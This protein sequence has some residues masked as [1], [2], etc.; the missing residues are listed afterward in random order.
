MTVAAV[1][2][3]IGEAEGGADVATGSK[4]GLPA[5]DDALPPLR[6]NTVAA[7]PPPAEVVPAEPLI[8]PLSSL[9]PPEQPAL[10]LGGTNGAVK[11][12][13]GQTRKS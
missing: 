11:S 10:P 9:V 7:V 13:P 6:G 3:I 1:A 8:V 5:A 12:E 2:V 4:E